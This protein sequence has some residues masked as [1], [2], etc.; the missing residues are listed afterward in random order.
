MLYKQSGK[1][2]VFIPKIIIP[3]TFELTEHNYYWRIGV[4]KLSDA[5]EMPNV[6]KASYKGKSVIGNQF[7]YLAKR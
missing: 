1:W 6:V 7:C 3:E 4:F 5:S 2:S